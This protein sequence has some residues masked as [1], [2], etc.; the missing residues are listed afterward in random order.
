LDVGDGSG[1]V[2]FEFKF[3]DIELHVVDVPEAFAVKP[4]SNP[5]VNPEVEFAA[6]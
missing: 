4:V 3:A 6:N 2:E 5:A 1:I